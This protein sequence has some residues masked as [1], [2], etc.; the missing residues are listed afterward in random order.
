MTTATGATA[1][2]QAKL[3]AFVGQ[4]VVDMGAATSGLLLDI[5][6]RLGLYEAMAGAG[7]PQGRAGGR[8]APPGGTRPGR[9]SRDERAEGPSRAASRWPGWV[10]PP[11]IEKH[12]PGCGRLRAETSTSVRFWVGAADPLRLNVC[13]C[14]VRMLSEG[15]VEGED[16]PETLAIYGTLLLPGAVAAA[17]AGDRHTAA[18]YLNEA[19]SMAR[20]LNRDTNLL[21]TAFGPTNVKIHRVTV[22]MALGDVQIALDLIPAIDTSGLPVERRARH[23]LEIANAYSARNKVEEAIGEL[24]LAERRAPEQIHGHIMSH[25]LVLALRGTGH[26]KRSRALVDLAR[27]MKTI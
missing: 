24:L 8:R 3:E 2:D 26:G 17:R 21:W 4:A 1:I 14:G 13:R 18:E 6:D 10:G 20:R 15:G 25:Q 27:R 19:E 23:S 22:A 12:P 11:F 5:G 16:R 7:R 9:S